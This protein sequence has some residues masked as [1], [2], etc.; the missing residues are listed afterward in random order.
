MI[1]LIL[2]RG[3]SP[4]AVSLYLPN[5]SAE[6]EKTF[7]AL[8]HISTES[9]TVVAEFNSS[10]DGLSQY[11]KSVNLDNKEDFAKLN[12]LAEKVST[13][14]AKESWIFSGALAA[15]SINGI[16]D[17]LKVADHLDDYMIVPNVNTDAELGRFIATIAPING[18]PRFPE[19]SWPY[20]DFA[21]IGAEYY[22]DH[23]GAYTYGGYVLRT[24]SSQR[25]M[26]KDGAIMSL[27]LETS[28]R[29]CILRLPAME[30]ELEETKARLGIDDFAQARV[31][32]V[33]FLIPYLEG[34]IPTECVSV[35]DANDLA[36]SIDEMNQHDG[37][38]LK[39]LSVLEVCQP[40]TMAEAL[41]YANNLDDYERVPD[42]PEE[43]GRAVLRRYGADEELINVIDGYMDFAGLGEDAMSE[44]GVRR[45]E[46]G[47]VRRCCEP[48][49]DE[50]Q[51]LQMSGM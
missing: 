28:E 47:L 33:N 32:C 2:G 36:L 5:T 19:E 10:V 24:P 21:K 34:H 39:Y 23:G 20:L 31:E 38:L 40:E 16:D 50:S 6:I 42:D 12:A 14:N 17:V 1:Q 3:D 25:E 48:F 7:A 13:M 9:P 46:F 18:D 26:R 4:R 35:E 27:Q 11:V 41:E 49:P 44:D 45:T 43:Y 15:N 51:G 22:A 30:E 37:W 8:D 29:A